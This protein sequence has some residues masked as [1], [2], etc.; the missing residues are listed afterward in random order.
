M[1]NQVYLNDSINTLKK[2]QEE[3][4]KHDDIGSSTRMELSRAIKQL[5][6]YA[7]GEKEDMDHN[8]IIQLIGKFIGAMP[9]IAKLIEMFVQH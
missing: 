8:E 9:A 2:I 6:L 4:E 1:S 5:E 7:L 3:M